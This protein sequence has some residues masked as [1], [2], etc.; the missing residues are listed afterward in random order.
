MPGKAMKR[1]RR[2]DDRTLA[3]KLGR[4]DSRFHA[5]NRGNNHSETGTHPPLSFQQKTRKEG[6]FPKP[7]KYTKPNFGALTELTMHQDV[8]RL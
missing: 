8:S 4:N 2:I 7:E 3:A 6:L 1:I 5:T